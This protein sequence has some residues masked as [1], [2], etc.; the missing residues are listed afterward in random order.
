MTAKG[1]DMRFELLSDGF[2][3]RSDF[4]IRPERS[5]GESAQLVACDDSISGKGQPM[6]DR[7]NV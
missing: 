6:I 4:L 1:N 2:D 3:A 7:T 5:V